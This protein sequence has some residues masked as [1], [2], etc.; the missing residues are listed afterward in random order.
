MT[1]IHV[2]HLII[3]RV[4]DK[5]IG[6]LILEL[7]DV[8]GVSTSTGLSASASGIEVISYSAAKSSKSSTSI[9]TIM[10]LSWYKEASS[11]IL[12]PS[13]RQG[14]HHVAKNSTIIYLSPAA[15]NIFSKSSLSPMNMLISIIKSEVE[16]GNVF[17][18][19]RNTLVI[20][21]FYAD[22]CP[23]CHIMDKYLKAISHYYRATVLKIDVNQFQRLADRYQLRKVI[24]LNC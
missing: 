21:D 7:F 13:M 19:A 11:S 3:R 1:I 18:T 23:P 9:L 22:W 16:L 14:P 2:H 24:Y 8:D 17:G 10:A 20:L 12:Q 6:F 15:V 4:A 5:R